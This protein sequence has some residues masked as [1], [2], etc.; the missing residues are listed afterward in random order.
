MDGLCRAFAGPWLGAAAASPR[1]QGAI[2]SSACCSARVYSLDFAVYKSLSL[3][4]PLF[5]SKLLLCAHPMHWT[6]TL[7]FLFID[8]EQDPPTD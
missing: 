2:R 6:L 5:P 7:R 1:A 3:D 4:F 8:E